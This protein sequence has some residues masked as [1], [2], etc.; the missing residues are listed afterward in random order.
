MNNSHIQLKNQN[1]YKN[2]FSPQFYYQQVPTNF[3]LKS[4]TTCTTTPIFFPSKPFTTSKFYRQ[5]LLDPKYLH[6]IQILK[7]LYTDIVVFNMAQLQYVHFGIIYLCNNL[8]YKALETM[9]YYLLVMIISEP[10]LKSEFD[11]IHLLIC[12]KTTYISDVLHI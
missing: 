1:N 12:R 4:F 3:F 11:T 2:P 5:M 9:L 6:E 8:I 10:E 7:Y